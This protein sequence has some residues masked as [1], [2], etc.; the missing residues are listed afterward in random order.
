MLWSERFQSFRTVDVK[1][2]VTSIQGTQV[3]DN[4][5]KY[6]HLGGSER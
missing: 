1:V 5:H 4:R 3:I 6:F 2:T